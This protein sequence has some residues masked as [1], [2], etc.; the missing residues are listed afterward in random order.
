MK[1]LLVMA[2]GMGS[3]FGGLKQMEAMGPNFETMLDYSV[4][5]AL[6]AGF[7]RVVF[8]IRAE[9]AQAF[10]SQIGARYQDRVVVDYV[11]Q[12]LHDLPD[13]FSV[14]PGRVKPWGT[15][16]AVWSA[17][18]AVSGPFAAINADDFYGRDAYKQ[19]AGFLDTR[20]APV[21]PGGSHH[22][23]MVGYNISKTL[24]GYG[25]VNRGI[26]HQR[27]GLLT[28]VQE[29]KNIAVDPDGVCRGNNLTG[30]RLPISPKAV[31]SM[32]IW[33]FTPAIFEQMGAHFT[34]FLRRHIT[35]LTAESYIPDVVDELIQSGQADCQI[36]PT[37]SAWFG[38]TYPQDKPAC[39]ENIA[40]LV[41]IGMYPVHLFPPSL[42]NVGANP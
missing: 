42:F 3:R 17:R 27:Q 9:F 41:S 29:Y 37:D 25:G 16:H 39:V 26:C 19:V 21:G 4:F 30:Q 10:Q 1:T 20:T 38:V 14:P 34:N 18:H 5:D 23:C 7:Q 33:G 13:G 24:S 31:S 8:V 11:F 2:A 32:N 6:Q 35:S 36:L 15:L 22:Y 40:K 28:T 12:D